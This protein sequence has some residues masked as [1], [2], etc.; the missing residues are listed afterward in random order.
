MSFLTIEDARAE[1]RID[2]ESEDDYLTKLIAR[3]DTILLAY[4]D[5]ESEDAFYYEYGSG[6]KHDIMECAAAKV[7]RN[8]YDNGDAD[9]LS[10]GVRQ[11][12]R[13]VR[14]P[15]VG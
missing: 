15:R 3:T 7:I 13:Q 12:L 5:F 11:L 9:P 1:L 10:D 14:T 2:D 6:P 8:L 4:V